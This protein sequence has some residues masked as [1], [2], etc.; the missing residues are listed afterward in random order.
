VQQAERPIVDHIQLIHAADEQ[1]S[2]CGHRFGKQWRRVDGRYVATRDKEFVKNVVPKSVAIHDLFNAM[3]ILQAASKN[4]RASFFLGA[5]KGT[6]QRVVKMLAE[7][8]YVKRTKLEKKLKK[9]HQLPWFHEVPRRFYM[10]DFDPT[11][12]QVDW[13][14]R[15]KLN[16]FDDPEGAVRACVNEFFQPEIARASYF[17]QLSSGAG[18]NKG[19]LDGAYIKFHIYFLLAEPL[20]PSVVGSWFKAQNNLPIARDFGEKLKNGQVRAGHDPSLQRN[21]VQLH[22]ITDPT[23]EN[24]ADPIKQRWF[25]IK[26]ETEFVDIRVE[27]YEIE[28]QLETKS[29]TRTIK[30]T[31]RS[32]RSLFAC[33]PRSCVRLSKRLARVPEACW[34]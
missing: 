24:C 33:A 29:G 30:R 28:E 19:D 27:T 20:I 17:F 15:Q 9:W 14:R 26:G 23:F 25:F 2:G 32:Q 16:V 21:I 11:P 13:C 22:Y 1:P 31:E 8:G 4:P 10:G 18:I 12:A 7:K 6:D 5:L 34:R 3:V